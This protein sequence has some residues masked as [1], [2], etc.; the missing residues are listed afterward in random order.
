MKPLFKTELMDKNESHLT[1][2]HEV[3]NRGSDVL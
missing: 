3:R 2:S 1:V